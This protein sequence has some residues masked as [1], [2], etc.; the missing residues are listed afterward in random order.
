MT[1]T[2][3]LTTEELLDLST[4]QNRM[5]RNVFNVLE[6]ITDSQN[7]DSVA[8]N[9]LLRVDYNVPMIIEP[10]GDNKIA[11]DSRIRA[12]LPT[13]QAIL[14]AKCNAIL[15][16]HMGRPKLV[17]KN[18]DKDGT[19][20]SKL[21]LRPVSERL[22]KLLEMDVGFATDCIGT[23]VERAV[24]SLPR[25]GGGLLLLEN[26]RFYSQEEKNEEKFAK[27]VNKSIIVE[28]LL[29]GLLP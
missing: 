3:N 5:K 12:S 24:A 2:E 6:Y 27:C 14:K 17:Q 1:T 8:K 16:S 26:L 29:C 18:L 28:I 23:D 4:P 11:D 10:D 20:R 13:I 9:I 7:D 22:S 15:I 19:E 25:E 21:S